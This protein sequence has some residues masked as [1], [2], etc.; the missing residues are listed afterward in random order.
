VEAESSPSPTA[1]GPTV[2]RAE[3]ASAFGSAGVTYAFIPDGAVEC[4]AGATVEVIFV[5][6]RSRGT[7]DALLRSGRFGHVTQS[8]HYDIPWCTRYVLGSRPREQLVLDVVCDPWAISLYGP[9]PQYLGSTWTASGTDTLSPAAATLHACVQS[10]LR[11]EGIDARPELV[12]A[13]ER[14]PV[15][16]ALLLEL[17]L[18]KAG[19]DIARELSHEAADLGSALHGVRL[20]IEAERR[21]PSRL[22]LRAAFS[23]MHCAQRLARPSGA[24]VGLAGPDGVG[25]STL[26]AGLAELE[27]HVFRGAVRLHSGPALLPKPAKLLG[28][29]VSDG[30]DPH[31][32]PPSGKFGS[33]LRLVYLGVD[34][35]LGW[36]P[37]VFLPKARGA[38]VIVERGWLDLAV[39]R[40]RYRLS[41]P[42]SAIRGLGAMLPREGVDLTLAMPAHDIHA[43]KPELE[44]P[45]IERQL[46]AWRALC[47]Q[48]PER[49]IVL[50]ASRPPAALIRDAYA[51]IVDRKAAGQL[52]LR[53]SAAAM[54]CLGP[55]SVSG[56]KFVVLS[57]GGLTRWILPV[58]KKARGPLR[59]S[60]YRPASRGHA[61]RALG[62]E[63]AVSLGRAGAFP[64]LH[65][66]ARR[67]LGPVLADLLGVR[68]VSLAAGVT[69]DADRGDRAVLSAHHGGKLIA[70][71]KVAADSG[72]LEHEK[73]VLDALA[74]AELTCISV[75]R[76]LG[77]LRWGEYS[78]L[79]LTPLN[80]T[81]YA[82]RP[83]GQR[84]LDALAELASLGP[85]LAHEL[86]KTD[87]RVPVHGDFTPW[88]SSAAGDRLQLW[89]WEST[90][91]GLPLEDH[92]HWRVQRLAL[93]GHG[94]PAGVAQ[95][96]KRPDAEVREL[97]ARTGVSENV[98]V[99]TLSEYVTR[100]PSISGSHAGQ[101]ARVREQI[102]LALNLP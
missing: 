49:F 29:R 72:I 76:V 44:I 6:R 67:G 36:W 96:A 100:T 34:T 83:S 51:A 45:E 85:C 12:A 37:K 99:E 11:G 82:D 4:P 38:L 91:L 24:V 43:R 79:V 23:V 90:R 77:F 56:K 20:A 74:G 68:E 54:S 53:S 31:G 52:D 42:T 63:A 30:T 102:A 98:A 28:R 15:G 61:I 10:A 84:E 70:F 73:R 50:D 59:S 95:A 3:L 17:S 8:Y 2:R 9:V 25:K 87:D 55:A 93:F 22:A 14:D 75:P 21:R 1:E 94:T 5:D 97:C 66:D 57:R 78:V 80:A 35:L 26:A 46:Q 41:T 32:R 92:F 60:L 7:L 19:R 86:G 81:D 69:S 39:D 71:A 89:D 58:E 13:F 48:K 33:Y 62:L 65:L 64:V 40:T 27:Q 88:N 101:I 18:G 16:A 47:E